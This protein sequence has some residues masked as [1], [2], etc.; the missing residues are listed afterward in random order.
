MPPMSMPRPPTKDRAT[1]EGTLV[2]NN[3]IIVYDRISI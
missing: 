3:F 2:M 1:I